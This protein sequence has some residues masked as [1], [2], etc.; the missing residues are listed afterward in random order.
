[1]NTFRSTRPLILAVLLL[2]AAVSAAEKAPVFP[3]GWR[4]DGTGVYPDAT[5]PMSWGRVGPVLKG[6]RCQAA[7]P[8]GDGE[9]GSPIPYGVI[10]DWLVL[11]PFE[12]NK[13]KALETEYLPKE[14]EL[15]PDVGE[16]VGELQWKA[17]KVE[18]HFAD[19][20][21]IFGKTADKAAYAHSY[22][23]APVEGALI[24]RTLAN[25]AGSKT[26]VHSIW[27]NG[28]PAN[29]NYNVLTFKK[30]WNEILLKFC[31]LN[32]TSQFY[33]KMDFRSTE[34]CEFESR[35]LA[36]A[37][38]LPYSA[39]VPIIV[40][41]KIFVCY[42][43][44]YLACFNKNDGKLLWTRSNGYHDAAD[45]TERSAHPEIAESAALSAKVDEL[46][47]VMLAGAPHSQPPKER[48]EL[49]KSIEKLM[50]KVDPVKYKP[51]PEQVS[52]AF[53]S[54]MT[55]CSDGKFVYAWFGTGVTVCYDLDGKRQWIRVDNRG[56]THHGYSSSPLLVDGKLVVYMRSVQAFDCKTGNVA[57]E[58][59][60]NTGN[61]CQFGSWISTKIG[62]TAVLISPMGPCVLRA[63]DGK[64]IFGK[65]PIGGC[66]ICTPVAYNGIAYCMD[67]MGPLT[68]MQ[69]TPGGADG[70]TVKSLPPIDIAPAQF[71]VLHMGKHN[72]ASSPVCYEGLLYAVDIEG[73]LIVLDTKTEAI[74]Y[75]QKLDINA[76]FSFRGWMW[77]H[78][79]G[80]CASLAIAGGKLY[81]QG[82]T[83]ITLIV[84]PGREF[85]LLAKNKIEAGGIRQDEWMEG[86]N[87]S[88]VFDGKSMYLRAENNLYCIREGR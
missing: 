79:A 42:E 34:P 28:K 35:N 16:K 88:P 26:V 29:P 61:L 70:V 48:A 72:F 71:P 19:F 40:G 75:Q 64:V 76:L 25:F 9:S 66:G 31:K 44:Y 10:T 78:E 49:L 54:G 55:P 69:L 50:L 13:E 65:L 77:P 6:L 53:Y 51:N 38:P 83:G 30:G 41:D 62:E 56:W 11:A 7:K 46:D 67:Q 23:Y 73:D 84:Q 60:W 4:G 20:D 68:R 87:C 74:V 27:F 85:K 2:T 8:K 17:M 58:Q 80:L 45:A 33:F 24:M 37:V 47:K 81:I 15:H 82:N 21:E 3:T 32:T 12:V 14:A 36:W 39:S 59:L 43:P 86:T 57:W 22:I 1:M 5:P 63:S 52:N 18:N